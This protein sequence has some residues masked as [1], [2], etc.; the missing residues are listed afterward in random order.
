MN[1]LIARE[2]KSKSTFSSIIFVP[3]IFE[4][5]VPL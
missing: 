5:G 2:S 4:I 1:K 3:A